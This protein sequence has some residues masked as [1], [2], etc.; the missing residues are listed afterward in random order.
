MLTQAVTYLNLKCLRVAGDLSV[1]ATEA[2][3]AH[4]SVDFDACFIEALATGS[5]LSRRRDEAPDRVADAPRTDLTR[6]VSEV[7]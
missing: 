5:G 1:E 7:C 6:T 3:L 2:K 4:F